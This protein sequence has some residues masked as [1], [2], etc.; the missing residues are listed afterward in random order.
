MYPSLN[1][2]SAGHSHFRV[3]LLYVA[4]IGQ[5]GTGI[6]LLTGTRHLPVSFA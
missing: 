5:V 2:L 1:I 3:T 4:P 6:V